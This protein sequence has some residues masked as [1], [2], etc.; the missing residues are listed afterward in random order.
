MAVKAK[1]YM[2]IGVA[3]GVIL[4]LLVSSCGTE[5]NIITQI[6]SNE[7]TAKQRL[8]SASAQ[9]TRKYGDSTKLLLIMG[10]N[11]KA[12]GKTDISTLSAIT[13]PDSIGAWLYVFRAPNDTSLRIYTPNP[14]PGSNDCIE[15]T[16]L[17]DSNTLL[18]LIADTSA[19]NMIS[20]ALSILISSSNVSIT[21]STSSLIDSDNSLNLANTTNP[22]IK[23]DS[24][25]APDTSSLNGNLFFSTGT[26]KRINM[27]LIPAV[28]T[29]HLPDFILDLTG[30]PPDLWIVNYKKKDLNNSEKSLILGTVVEGSQ[31]MHVANIGISSKVINLSKYAEE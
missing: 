5:E 8:D 19:K 29:L 4:L 2:I 16:A 13:N 11:V 24:S 6:F 31:I 14:I 22:I 21:T 28:G 10:K 12:N 7:V 25:F 1:S 26:G 18:S 20:G 23:F 17:F 15:L 3:I 30:F 9:A 27:F